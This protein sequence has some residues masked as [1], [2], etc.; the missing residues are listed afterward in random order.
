MATKRKLSFK[1]LNNPRR[2]RFGESTSPIEAFGFVLDRQRGSRRMYACEDVRDLVNV[3][4]R[5][6]GKAK[7]ARVESFL[8]LVGRQGLRFEEDER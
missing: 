4:P 1:G 7:A 5:S 2:L 6:D 3:Q 8:T